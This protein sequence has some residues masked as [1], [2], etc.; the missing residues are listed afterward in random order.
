MD[1]QLD[2]DIISGGDDSDDSEIEDND[3]MSGFEQVSNSDVSE[4]NSSTK[5]VQPEILL[6]KDI[7][8]FIKN[9][10]IKNNTKTLPYL[11][12]YEKTTSIG[13]RAEQISE[14]SMTFLTSDESLDLTN[15]MDIAEKE[16]ELGKIPFIIKRP[17]SNNN[18]EYWKLNDLK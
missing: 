7:D 11:T 9:Y 4:S 14:G 18:F 6:D 17:I 10:S 12:K 2:C 3:N 13:M 8:L 1:E 15:V 16:F 5:Q